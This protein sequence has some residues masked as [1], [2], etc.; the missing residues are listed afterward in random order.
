MELVEYEVKENLAYIRL[1]R[2]DK[3]NAIN[4]QMLRELVTAFRRC[5]E[6]SETWVAILSGKGRSFCA[7]HDQE[8][9]AEMAPEDLFL[10]MLNL[11]KPLLV[12]VQGHCVGMALAMAFSS[13]IR[14]GA[15]GSL[16]GWPN[17]RWGQS[18][19]GGP[20]FMPH[21]I[22][23]NYAFEYMFTGNLISAGEA[24]RLGLLNRIVPLDELMSKAEEIAGKI[25]ENAPLAVRAMKEATLNGYD[26][27]M[28]QRLALS[29]IIAQRVA[30]TEDAK[31]GLRAFAEKRQPVW[32]GK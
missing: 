3:L 9:N 15:E 1:N 6:D 20:A 19:I 10:Q 7:G 28:P 8:E 25:S 17:V 4:S 31:E 27:P 23:R 29:K 16:Y 26:L 30:D 5:E 18:S 12:A 32:K 21:Y 13:D 24:F 11:S 2:P 14:I 22:P